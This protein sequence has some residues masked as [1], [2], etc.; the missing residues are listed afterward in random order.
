MATL[1]AQLPTFRHSRVDLTACAALALVALLAFWVGIRPVFD[2]EE[3]HRQMGVQLRES[4]SQLA[5]R[6]Q[7]YAQVQQAIGATKERL[8]RSTVVLHTAEGLATRQ[9][10]VSA[11]V[12]NAGIELEQLTV[13]TAV[14]G[15]LLDTIPLH[16]T[17]QGTFPEVVAVMHELRTRFPDM[18]ITSF[19]ISGGGATG[20]GSEKNASSVRFLLDIAWYTARSGGSRG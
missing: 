11:A 3:R 14:P 16:V 19:Q 2:A 17:G 15:D 5:A 9:E 1:H 20:A 4:R 13:G 8:R 18:A 10:E 6:R 7:E 12:V